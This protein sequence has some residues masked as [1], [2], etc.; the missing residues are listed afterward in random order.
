MKKFLLPAKRDALGGEAPSSMPPSRTTKLPKSQRAAT[1]N[2]AHIAPVVIK[3][4]SDGGSDGAFEGSSPTAESRPK[5][6]A[7]PRKMRVKSDETAGAGAPPDYSFPSF[8]SDIEDAQNSLLSWYA[9]AL[10]ARAQCQC[11]VAPSGLTQLQVRSKQAQPS[12]E[13]ADGAKCSLWC[14]GI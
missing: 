5:K 4:E 10:L 8:P 13:A 9:S 11:S 7:K 3:I 12:L 2:V 1:E 6:A 14:V